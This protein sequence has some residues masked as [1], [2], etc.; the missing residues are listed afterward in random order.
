[1]N[2]NGYPN[3]SNRIKGEKANRFDEFKQLDRQFE[4]KVKAFHDNR[5]AEQET[6][7]EQL[8]MIEKDLVQIYSKLSRK[9]GLI[10]SY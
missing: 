6:Y 3:P 2:H 1:M 8:F 5:E 7:R 4:E 10:F 9:R